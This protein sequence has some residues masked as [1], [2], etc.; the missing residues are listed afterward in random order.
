M[1]RNCGHNILIPFGS[2]HTERSN[3]CMN[4]CTHTC[5]CSPAIVLSPLAHAAKPPSEEPN[6][7]KL[8]NVSLVP[9]RIKHN[10]IY[11]FRTL[12]CVR[13]RFVALL[14]SRVVAGQRV[15]WCLGSSAIY[16]RPARR[17]TTAI[18]RAHIYHTTTA[19][20][21]V[22]ADNAARALTQ[23]VGR[24]VGRSGRQDSA[25]PGIV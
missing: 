14:Q 9:P 11:I 22:H 19:K 13:P 16:A 24:L 15:V 12:P 10:L 23:A 18:V 25:H 21:R 17:L 5:V 8:I 1:I 7:I 4:M 6:H 20:K 2:S 3:Y